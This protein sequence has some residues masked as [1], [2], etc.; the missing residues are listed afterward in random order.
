MAGAPNWKPAPRLPAKRK[1][2][3]PVAARKIEQKLERK[4]FVKEK[5]ASAEGR[6]QFGFAGLHCD[7]PAVHVHE[8][9]LRSQ[10]GAVIPSQGLDIESCDALCAMHHAW[11]HNHPA[12]AELMGYLDQHGTAPGAA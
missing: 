2:L 12:I 10:G 3:P 5:I 8:R 11:L 4:E 7:Q 9:V 1:P 6:C